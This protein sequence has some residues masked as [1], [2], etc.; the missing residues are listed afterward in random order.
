MAKKNKAKDR[1]PVLKNGSLTIEQFLW[2]IE[3][4]KL[5]WLVRNRN[6]TIRGYCPPPELIDKTN[7]K[8]FYCEECYRECQKIVKNNKLSFK[9]GKKKY[10]KEDLKIPEKIM[11][12]EGFFTR[13]EPV[14]MKKNKKKKK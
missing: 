8:C 2:L 7:S 5:D 4:D 13:Q 14:E 9:I 12:G 11:F 6:N 3:N 10:D 1:E